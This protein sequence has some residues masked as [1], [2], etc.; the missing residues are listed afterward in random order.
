[1]EVFEE[2]LAHIVDPLQRARTVEIFT[3]IKE[4]FRSVLRSNI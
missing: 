3:W 2:Y 1:M 4:Q